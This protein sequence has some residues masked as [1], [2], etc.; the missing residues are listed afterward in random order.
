MNNHV[1][2]SLGYS[3]IQLPSLILRIY[4]LL[5]KRLLSDFTTKQ[6]TIYNAR[7][8]AMKTLNE[9]KENTENWQSK[10]DNTSD[11]FWKLIRELS[12]KMTLLHDRMDKNDKILEN[13]LNKQ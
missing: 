11:N 12:T 6:R 7:V 13:L 3:L 2:T 9:V 1:E 5:Q 8:T 4:D 10:D